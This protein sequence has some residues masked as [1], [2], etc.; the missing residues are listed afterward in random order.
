MDFGTILCGYAGPCFHYQL[1]TV[2]GVHFCPPILQDSLVLGGSRAKSH[3]NFG[4]AKDG[5]TSFM[6]DSKASICG[7][8]DAKLFPIC[9]CI[10]AVADFSSKDNDRLLSCNDLATSFIRLFVLVLRA[11]SHHESCHPLH[12]ITKKRLQFDFISAGGVAIPISG[13]VG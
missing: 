8:G 3:L 11:E 9:R 2:L 1:F 6:L 5:L 4:E 7:E 12:L 13:Y 10:N